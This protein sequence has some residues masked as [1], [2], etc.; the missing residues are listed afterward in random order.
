M[1]RYFV[2]ASALLLFPLILPAQTS[3]KPALS[4]EIKD[5]SGTLAFL[6]SEWMEG[7]EAG[8]R[9]SF[10]AADYIASMMR[11]F[12]LDPYGDTLKANTVKDAEKITPGEGGRTY[13]QDF[14]VTSRQEEKHGHIREIKVKPGLQELRNVLGLIRGVDTTKSVIVGAHYDHLGIRKGKIYYGSDDNASG[15]AGML[16]LAKAWNERGEKPPF[17]IIFAAWTSE[18]N[19]HLGSLYFVE[20]TK[21]NPGKIIAYINMDMISRSAPEDTTHRQLSIGTMTVSEN[22]RQIAIGKNSRMSPPFELDLW[23]VTGQSGSDYASFTPVEIP[24]MTF[25]SGYNEDYHAPGDVAG[26]ADFQKM[27]DIL[28]LVN[29]CLRQVLQ[30][31]GPQ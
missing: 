16:A 29:E 13:F 24:V 10:L 22:L 28:E 7:R 19:G 20:K 14:K 3:L 5:C 2:L 1:K 30:Q 25:F 6:S 17:N 11:L 21:A 23:D 12:G 4:P 18:E 9:G 8:S 27:K 31:A 26:K 15:V